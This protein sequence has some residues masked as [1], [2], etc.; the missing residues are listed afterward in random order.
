MNV[1]Q[2]SK[3]FGILKIKSM[4]EKIKSIAELFG[5][6]KQLI[7]FWRG[8]GCGN[9]PTIES[10]LYLE[11]TRFTENAGE[12]TVHFEQK[13]WQ[14]NENGEIIKPLHWESGFFLPTE[15]GHIEILNAQNSRRVEVLRGESFYE[16]GRWLLNTKS[17]L[18]GY[19]E[20]MKETA[21]HFEV[22]ENTMRYE[23]QM[24]TNK[25]A[26]LQTH[27]QADLKKVL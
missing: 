12:L 25:I 10:F 22:Y 27:L 1:A 16:N 24:A 17:V 18:H 11:E 8:S 9:F 13:S 3:R 2:D 5:E 23:L 6:L 14:I 7:G 26:E 15:D 21:R 20:R 4:N 19:D